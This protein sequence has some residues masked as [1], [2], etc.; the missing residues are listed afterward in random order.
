MMRHPGGNLPPTILERR[1]LANLPVDR[2]SPRAWDDDL[3]LRLPDQAHWR[4]R[5][6]EARASVRPAYRVGRRWV[7]HN[8]RSAVLRR[9][10]HIDNLP[11]GGSCLRSDSW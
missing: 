6:R 1:L 5:G 7:P 10:L 2:D 9:W 4:R 8:R 11:S 3:Q